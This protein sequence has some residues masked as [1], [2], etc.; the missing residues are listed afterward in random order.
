VC[1]LIAVP[2]GA[3]LAIPASRL[4]GLFLALATFG[5]GLLLQ[6]MFYTKSFMFG[7]DLSGVM[8]P[9]PEWSFVDVASD[10]G[11]Y[12][13]VLAIATL[14][15]VAVV[16][17][18]RGRLGRLLRAMA[19]S[20]H[21]LAISGAN[22]HVSRLIV[23]CISA[24]MAAVGGALAAVAQ[25]NISTVTY[26][27]LLSLTFFALILVVPGGAPWNSLIA[28][29]GLIL[30]PS[31]VTDDQVTLW[32][33]LLI[34]ASAVLVA[35]VPERFSGVPAPLRAALD[36]TFRRKPLP[37]VALA[38]A[39]R[40]RVDDCELEVAGLSV[41]FGGV[42]AVDSF[43]LSART[44][45]ITGLIGPNGAGKTTTFNACSGLVRPSRGR[46]RLRGRDITRQGVSSR[47]RHGLGRTF[48]RMELLE[49]RTVRE[50]VAIGYEGGLAGANPLRHLLSAPGDNRTTAA[51]VED[52][53]AICELTDLAHQAVRDLSTGQRR[54]VEL[55]RCAV[56]DFSILLLDEPSSGLDRSETARFG[57]VLQT[58]VADRGVG[59][60]LVEHDMGLVLSICDEVTVLD[61]GRHLFTGR[62]DEA[63]ADPGV[64]AAY[65]GEAS[66]DD[67]RRSPHVNA[68][69][70]S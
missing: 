68:G 37:D 40:G 47:A 12:Y 41:R 62:P 24:F 5:F 14:G 3:L 66:V 22:A 48:Q 43:S 35:V 15:A 30:V 36:R 63:V 29:G 32:L 50:N 13:L 39:E 38:P 28:A 20:P 49:S 57:R 8:M 6:V 60:L 65:L 44:G 17:L 1:G 33:Q 18:F 69:A 31:Y 52:A 59:I 21:A 11:Y 34:G 61:F 70:M 9:R 58:L 7:D 64:Q 23:F 27:P 4:G 67:S 53:L 25:S 16:A 55:A 2:V 42:V 56:G 51:R 46:I 45:T 10:R 19:D 26:P 54:L